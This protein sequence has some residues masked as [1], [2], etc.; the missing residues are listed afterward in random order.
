MRTVQ[1]YSQCNL[2]IK[3]RIFTV[4][5]TDDYAC[6]IRKTHH[7]ASAMTGVGTLLLQCPPISNRLQ[8]GHPGTGVPTVSYARF[9]GAGNLF[10]MVLFQGTAGRCGHRPL[11]LT[12]SAAALDPYRAAM[13]S[14][15][16]SAAGAWQSVL[17]CKS[18]ACVAHG[19]TG[20]DADCQKVN[21][22]VGKRGHPGVRQCAHW[23]AMT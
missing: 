5:R 16:A 8:N 14:V 22:P 1:S 3:K 18:L 19:A 13:F 10:P 6:K 20:W 21:C 12:A 2:I 7:A 23:L 17:F 11:R 9:R 15:T 4:N